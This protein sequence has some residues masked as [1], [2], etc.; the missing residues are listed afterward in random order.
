[1]AENKWFRLFDVSSTGKYAIC[2]LLASSVALLLLLATPSNYADVPWLVLGFPLMYVPWLLA[3]LPLDWPPVV[4]LLLFLGLM[5]ANS[6]L[7]GHVVVCGQRLLGK[8]LSRRA[9]TRPPMA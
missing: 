5:T 6:Y 2:H 1:M 7:W 4:G 8:V 9:T 3:H